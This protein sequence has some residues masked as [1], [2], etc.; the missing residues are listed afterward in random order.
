MGVCPQCL[1]ADFFV[2]WSV[3]SRCWWACT[4]TRLLRCNQ[5]STVGES[6]RFTFHGNRGGWYPRIYWNGVSSVLIW[7]MGGNVPSLPGYWHRGCTGSIQSLDLPSLL[8]HWLWD[9]TPMLGSLRPPV[10]PSSL[11]KLLTWTEPPGQSQCTLE[12]QSTWRRGWMS[13]VVSKADIRPGRVI[14]WWDLENQSVITRITVLCWDGGRSLMKSM[15]KRDHGHWDVGNG[16]SSPTAGSEVLWLEH[17][18]NMMWRTCWC[19]AACLATSISSG[20]AIAFCECWGVP[21][22]GGMGL[23]D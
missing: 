8:G 14:K 19:L 15:A 11:V 6:V 2:L 7:S 17:K 13:S 5:L 21:C 12:C 9:D 16:M 1:T 18:Q 22:R 23:C 4:H 20:T 10:F 3:C